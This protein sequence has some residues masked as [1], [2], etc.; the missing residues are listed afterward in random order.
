MNIL[1]IFKHINIHFLQFCNSIWQILNTSF[2]L[3]RKVTSNVIYI[4][5]SISSNFFSVITYGLCNSYTW[6]EN[7]WDYKTC[8]LGIMEKIC[9]LLVKGIILYYT[10][11]TENSVVHIDIFWAMLTSLRRTWTVFLLLLMYYS[12]V[13]HQV[14]FFVNSN[15]FW[16]V[17][18]FQ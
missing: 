18:S 4:Y 12:S 6:N 14:F 2:S 17:L 16:A 8:N 11:H 5:I 10:V 15:I 7:C 9:F 13:F 3:Y 1:S